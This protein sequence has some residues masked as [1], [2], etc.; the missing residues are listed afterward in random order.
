MNP[1]EVKTLIEE[2][3]K[4]RI[5]IDNTTSPQKVLTA[6]SWLNAQCLY[7]GQGYPVEIGRAGGFKISKKVAKAESFISAKAPKADGSKGATD[8]EADATSEI[9]ATTMAREELTATE[10]GLQLQNL[11][12]DL[13]ELINIAK[14]KVKIMVGE[15][16]ALGQQ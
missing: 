4:H 5:T 11:R 14:V 6:M 8:K 10:F 16:Q 15:V 7:L 1:S 9:E 3:E 12:N 13:Q 2:T